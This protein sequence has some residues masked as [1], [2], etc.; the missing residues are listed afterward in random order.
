MTDYPIENILSVNTQDN[1]IYNVATSYFKP[2]ST[3]NIFAPQT[4]ATNRFNEGSVVRVRHHAY[5]SRGNVLTSSL[6]KGTLVSY[7]W[8]YNAQ[9]PVAEVKNAG[10]ADIAFAGFEA[11]GKGNW[12]YTGG[13]LVDATAPGGRRAYNLSG[14]ALSKGGL[15]AAKQY[16]LSYWAKS[17]TATAISGGAATAIV[18]RNGWTLYSRRLTGVTTVTLSGAVMIDEIRLHP[19]DAEMN[20]YTYDPLTGMTSSTDPS[21][22]TTYYSYD[23][24]G[25]LQAVKDTQ[26]KTKETYEYHYRP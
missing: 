21:G 23:G 3:V 25:R 2:I 13:T 17:T 8:S 4:V 10:Q 20:T 11:E 19:A 24:S 12:I 7:L 18:S 14:G 6:E 15:T 22:R 26:Q 16:T 9:Y 1:M 5:D